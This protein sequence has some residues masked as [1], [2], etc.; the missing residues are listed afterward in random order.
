MNNYIETIKIAVMIFPFIAFIVSI[1]FILIQYHKFGSLSFLRGLIIYSFTLY[2]ICAY[3]LVIL[4]LPKISQVSLLTTP[5]MQLIPFNFIFDFIKHTSFN[6]KEIHTYLIAIKESYFFV[7]IYNVFLT[8]P[9]GIYLRYYFRCNLKKTIMLTFILSLFFEL[10][11]LSGLYFI[12]PRGYRLFDI[13]DLILNTLGGTIGF[14]L[15][16]ILLKILP[17][18]EKIDLASKERG[19]KI[20][21]FRR[22]VT[23]LLDLFLFLIIYGFVVFFIKSKYIFYLILLLYYFIIPIFLNSSTLGE[24]FLNMQIL[25][26]SNKKNILRLILRRLLF[27]LIYLIVP[28]SI[29]YCIGNIKNSEIIKELIGIIFMILVFII[30]LISGIKYVFT[31]KKMLYEKLSKT[32]AISTIK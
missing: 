14:F 13:D 19:K 3:F 16:A 23:F 24:K 21:G 7:P 30:Y 32:Q 17:K 5:R 22:T 27:L 12:Y 6:I 18:K 8:L 1:P 9:F 11:Q 4:P 15:S 20:S 10:T 2:L 31:S 29:F 25:D 28:Y 26:N